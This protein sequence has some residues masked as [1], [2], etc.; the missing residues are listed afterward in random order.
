[1]WNYPDRVTIEKL[2]VEDAR[3]EQ[4]G[5]SIDDLSRNPAELCGL[6]TT[7]CMVDCGSLK[8]WGL[9][10]KNVPGAP[11]MYRIVDINANRS[12]PLDYR[13]CGSKVCL[14]QRGPN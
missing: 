9:L 13:S 8:R 3:C 4:S 11:Y 12:N 14:F 1:M 5:V 6:R 7:H 2:L 10:R